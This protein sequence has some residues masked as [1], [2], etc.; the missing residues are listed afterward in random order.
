VRGQAFEP[1]HPAAVEAVEGWPELRV[2]LA[3]LDSLRF[4]DLRVRRVAEDFLAD[5][6]RQGIWKDH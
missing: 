5:V 4:G 3:L 1:L 2:I 6:L